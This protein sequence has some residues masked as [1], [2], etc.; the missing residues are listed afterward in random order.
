MLCLLKKVKQVV[1]IAT[2]MNKY[3]HETQKLIYKIKC[4]KYVLNI[5]T[6]PLMKD[7]T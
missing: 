6:L 2:S 5:S 3:P 7:Q 4:A 1:G